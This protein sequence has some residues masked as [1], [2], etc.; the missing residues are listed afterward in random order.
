MGLAEI[1][2]SRDMITASKHKEALATFRKRELLCAQRSALN[3]LVWEKGER[4]KNHTNGAD[5]V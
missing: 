2:S 5:P 3:T 4:A 1:N